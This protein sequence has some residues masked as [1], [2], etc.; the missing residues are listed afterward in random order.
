VI[1]ALIAA[2]AAI[3]AKPLLSQAP[4]LVQ[5]E[6]EASLLFADYGSIKVV[7]GPGCSD[8]TLTPDWDSLDSATLTWLGE[9]KPCRLG[10]RR[11][12]GPRGVWAAEVGDAWPELDQQIVLLPQDRSLLVP[13][14]AR[15]F[16]LE[17]ERWEGPLGAGRCLI[18]IYKPQGGGAASRAWFFD[19]AHDLGAL[20]GSGQKE[21]ADGW[22]ISEESPTGAREFEV[23]AGKE[24]GTYRWVSGG[25]T[26]E[27]VLERTY[28][29]KWSEG[30]DLPE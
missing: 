20:T 25:Q 16:L 27:A 13:S 2:A 22:E 5:E 14:S 12:P 10:V 11:L 8:L 24:F 7:L 17:V 23:A 3:G 29:G 28:S 30:D 6:G 18:W 4:T 19:D 1:A 26:Q 15:D 21:G 9:G